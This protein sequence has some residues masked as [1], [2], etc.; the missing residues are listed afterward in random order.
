M[1]MNRFVA[2]AVH[3]HFELKLQGIAEHKYQNVLMR[4]SPLMSHAIFKS[5]EKYTVK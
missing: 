4:H 3:G 2:L 5:H 1:A